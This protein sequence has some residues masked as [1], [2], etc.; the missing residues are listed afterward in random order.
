MDKALFLDRDG[1]INIEKNYLYKKEDFEFI[2][3]IFDL[4]QYYQNLG[5]KIFVVTNQSG[6]ARGYYSEEDFLQLTQW[7]KKEFI[8]RNIDIKRVYYCPHHPD[9]TGT[10]DCRKPKPGMILQAKEEFNIDLSKSLMIGDSERDIQAALNAG[11]T[12][13]YL[14]SNDMSIEKSQATKIVRNLN[15]IWKKRC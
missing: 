9:I 11:I 3:G 4:C 6:I 15:E 12:E 8:K 14:L 5:Y 1:V 2:D 13:S 10:C 7:M